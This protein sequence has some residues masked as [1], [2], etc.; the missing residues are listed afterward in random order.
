MSDNEVKMLWILLVLIKI[1]AW[2]LQNDG[3]QGVY[4]EAMVTPISK[5]STRIK[6]KEH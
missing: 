3:V 6:C 2:D 1:G 5:I 4:L